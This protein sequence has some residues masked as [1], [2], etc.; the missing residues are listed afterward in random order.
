MNSKNTIRAAIVGGLLTT[1]LLS[2]ARADQAADVGALQQQ[3]LQLQQRLDALEAD[4]KTADAALQ[5][6]ADANKPDVKS[7]SNFD[8]TVS[9]LV[10][11]D[12]YLHLSGNGSEGFDTFRL[13]RGQIQL[14]AAID[15][16]LSGTIMID[17]AKDNIGST[18]RANAML[19]VLSL[20][21]LLNKGK[22]S[23]TYADAGQVKLPLG[24]E[25]YLTSA[26]LPLV[27]RSMLFTQ[28]LY[29]NVYDTGV[30]LHGNAGK[31]QYIAGVFNGLG[32]D[33]NNIATRDSKAL[34]GRVLWKAADGLQIGGSAAK[35]SNGG[36]ITNFFASYTKSK[37][38]LSGEYAKGDKG[39][40]NTIVPGDGFNLTAG[41]RLAPKLEAVVRYDT[42]NDTAAG[43]GKANEETLGLN[44]YLKGDNA[45]IQLNLVKHDGPLDSSNGTGYLYDWT[46]LR[47]GFQVGF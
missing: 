21:Y 33:Q 23:A 15:P 22:D 9:G 16:R 4:Q 13:R 43:E 8:V 1:T 18:N 35:G 44:Y 47:T 40:G 26:S 11:V 27:E 28:G 10:Q 14:D 41:Y 17:A 38:W 36:N 32:E 2:G 46:E 39:S 24:Y 45:K 42:F 12:S 6:A 30:Q 7:K 31:L 34:A 5:K 19:Q 25:G 29:G 20:S 37:W 3:I